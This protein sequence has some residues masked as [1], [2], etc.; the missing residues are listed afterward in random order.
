MTPRINESN[1]Q[2]ALSGFSA[3]LLSQAQN[4]KMA[5]QMNGSSPLF[6]LLH[7]ALIKCTQIFENSPNDL[8]FRTQSSGWNIVSYKNIQEATQNTHKLKI[9]GGYPYDIGLFIQESPL[10]AL[11]DFD[12]LGTI[13]LFKG[14]PLGSVP[15]KIDLH[16]YLLPL[17][18]DY[19]L[20]PELWGP[21]GKWTRFHRELHTLFDHYGLF[22]DKDF[23]G[24]YPLKRE[25]KWLSEQGFH[26]RLTSTNFDLIPT[27]DFPLSGLVELKTALARGP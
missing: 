20:S 25:A 10:E 17:W 7:P 24:F 5:Y 16:H 26:G 4:K 12:I 18:L 1:Q 8:V 14:E 2:T 3:Q 13:H 11:I 6:Q 15:K 9:Y 22:I 21:S 19:A 27:W 23:P